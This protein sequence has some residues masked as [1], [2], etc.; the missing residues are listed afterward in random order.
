MCELKSKNFLLVGMCSSQSFK[1]VD[2]L[3][4]FDVVTLL[5]LLSF[6]IILIFKW[7]K[8]NSVL[9][10]LRIQINRVSYLK[11]LTSSFALLYN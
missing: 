2:T 4:L 8:I 3:L 5:F 11:I 1:L 6:H 7:N 10:I 9:R